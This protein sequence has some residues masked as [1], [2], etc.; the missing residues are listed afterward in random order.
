MQEKAKIEIA[1]AGG[2]YKARFAGRADAC[3]GTTPSEAKDRLKTRIA[4]LAGTKKTMLRLKHGPEE[5][6]CLEMNA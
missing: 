1:R 6:R 3:F 5:G 4:I 2:L